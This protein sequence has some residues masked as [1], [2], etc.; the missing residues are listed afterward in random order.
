M[1]LF[2]ENMNLIR[3]L[4]LFVRLTESDAR[5]AFYFY[6]ELAVFILQD[7]LAYHEQLCF[8]NFLVEDF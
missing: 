6:L 4:H 7:L 3:C 2:Y 5:I 8:V 1:F